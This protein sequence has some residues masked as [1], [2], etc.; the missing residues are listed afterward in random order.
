MFTREGLQEPLSTAIL[1]ITSDQD[2]E[3]FD[4]K[5][6]ILSVFLLFAQASQADSRVREALS[7]RAILR[8]VLYTCSTLQS[9][10]LVVVLKSIK[11]LSTNTSTL[12]VLHNA[13]A[14][15][16][17]TEVLGKHIS[18]SQSTEICNHALQTLYN[19]CRMEKSR[20]NEAAQAGV[21]PYLKQI[22]EASSPLKQFALPY[23]TSPFSGLLM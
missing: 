8:R 14:I 3:A 9:T 10:L 23:V 7:Q 22:I 15:E 5:A 18:G 16:V 2:E 1:S 13:N 20:Q 12:V 21:I 6:Q 11:H 17:L 4:S 19:L